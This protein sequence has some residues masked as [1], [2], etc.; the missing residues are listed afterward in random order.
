MQSYHYCK[1]GIIILYRQWPISDILVGSA[2]KV[3]FLHC[4]L[5]LFPYCETQPHPGP[6]PKTAKRFTIFAR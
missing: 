3:V 4:S 6:I 5:I 1:Q 2:G